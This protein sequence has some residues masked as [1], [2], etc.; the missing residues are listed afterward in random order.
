[1]ATM[2]VHHVPRLTR[3]RYEEVVRRLTDGKRRLESPSD[4]P[5]GGLLV[6]VAD[7][8]QACDGRTHGCRARQVE[9]NVEGCME[10]RPRFPGLRSG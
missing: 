3:E 10:D 6:N 5:T 1:M 4:V 8:N 2:V 7:S 9:P